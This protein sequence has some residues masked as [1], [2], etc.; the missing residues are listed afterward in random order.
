MP[1][2]P[3]LGVFLFRQ[4]VRPN[5]SSTTSHDRALLVGMAEPEPT[6]CAT[7]RSALHVMVGQTGV[8]YLHK[9]DLSGDRGT[10]NHEPQPVLLSELP[11][12]EMECDFCSAPSPTYLYRTD[13]YSASH[14]VPEERIVGLAEHR[15]KSYAAHSIREEGYRITST[16][17]TGWTACV[18]CAAL[19]DDRDLNGLVQ[20]VTEAMPAKLTRGKKLIAVRGRLFEMYGHLFETLKSKSTLQDK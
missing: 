15:D 6:Y 16:T 2:S 1:G 13:E 14:F 12:P 5:V 7:C 20:R 4:Y 10:I 18:D 11:N 19:V 8:R 9:R 3:S 17:D